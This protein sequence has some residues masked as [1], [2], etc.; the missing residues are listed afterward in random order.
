MTPRRKGPRLFLHPERAAIPLLAPCLAGA[1]I[2]RADGVWVRDSGGHPVLALVE[3]P[4]APVGTP[5]RAQL[6]TGLIVE[7]PELLLPALDLMWRGAG[8]TQARTWATASLR[9]EPVTA[10]LIQDLRH[11]RMHGYR[12]PKGV[13]PG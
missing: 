2:A 6:A 1:R 11:A 10:W 3:N 8:I 9:R 4:T 5:E 12:L 13:T 7:V